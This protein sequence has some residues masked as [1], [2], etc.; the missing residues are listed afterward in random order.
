MNAG[1]RA[2][3]KHFLPPQFSVTGTYNPRW[4]NL[5]AGYRL[6]AHAEIEACL[7]AI[8]TA[9][10]ARCVHEWK[11]KHRI[12]LTTVSLI[13]YSEAYHKI[14]EKLDGLQKPDLLSKLENAHVAFSQ[15]ARGPNHGI[16]E[17]NVLHLLF[18]VGIRES[19]IDRT[20]LQKIDAFGQHRGA[21]AHKSGRTLQPIDPEDEYKTVS[22]IADGIRQIDLLLNK[23][24]Y[25]THELSRIPRR[26]LP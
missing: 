25:H 19:H 9:A 17:N 16:R 4:H 23:M 24:K 14:P 2:L 8:A 21:V 22:S 6:L 18:T 1:L 12:G 13:A 15:F 26:L 3:R 20:W 5:A 11:Y 7:E 10:S